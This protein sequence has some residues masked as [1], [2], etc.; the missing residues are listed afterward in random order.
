MREVENTDFEIDI[1][2]RG[3]DKDFGCGPYD[4]PVLDSA[5]DHFHR[6][7]GGTR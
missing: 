6:Q 7:Q 5:G 4:V 3:E 2:D 1:I